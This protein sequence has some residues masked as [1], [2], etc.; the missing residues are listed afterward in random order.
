[1][2]ATRISR[3]FTRHIH[4]IRLYYW[5]TTLS[6]LYSSLYFVLV[7]QSNIQLRCAMMASCAGGLDQTSSPQSNIGFTQV[8]NECPSVTRKFKETSLQRFAKEWPASWSAHLHPVPPEQSTDRIPTESRPLK[9]RQRSEIQDNQDLK[10]QNSVSTVWWKNLRT[11]M[12]EPSTAHL[13]QSEASGW[14][15]RYCLGSRDFMDM[16]THV[17][18]LT[19]SYN[20]FT[21]IMRMFLRMLLRMLRN[22]ENRFCKLLQDA[23]PQSRCDYKEIAALPDDKAKCPD[24]TQ[25]RSAPLFGS[26]KPRLPKPFQTR[27]RRKT[28]G[29][30]DVHWI[31]DLPK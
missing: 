16:L 7:S 18:T 3:F 25:N 17:D 6:Q 19:I 29:F 20:F 12:F 31:T 22:N 13:R 28:T 24:S 9:H 26:P 8:L 21:R 30:D 5:T 11:H 4:F 10:N 15:S 2:H 23:V 1:M 27:W 14:R